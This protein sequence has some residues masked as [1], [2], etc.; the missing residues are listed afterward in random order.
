LSVDAQGWWERDFYVETR[1]TEQNARGVIA[2]CRSL[3]SVMDSHIARMS[4]TKMPR[5][6]VSSLFIQSVPKTE[7]L[8]Y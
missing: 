3:G 8:N 1:L 4:Q 6:A 7:P 2:G 5:S